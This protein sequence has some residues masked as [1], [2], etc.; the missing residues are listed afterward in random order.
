MITDQTAQS[1]PSAAAVTERPTVVHDEIQEDRDF[2]SDER[3]DERR[4]ATNSMQRE[5]NRLVHKKTDQTN[6]SKAG[7]SDKIRV[8][9][10]Q[11]ER[12]LRDVTRP[13]EQRGRGQLTRALASWLRSEEHTSELQSPD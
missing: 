13:L 6:E 12:L 10:I 9:P 3:G 11:S 1:G 5:Q 8:G 4:L 2:D 7:D